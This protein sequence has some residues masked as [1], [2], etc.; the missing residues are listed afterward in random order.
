[1]IFENL[2]M[3]IMNLPFRLCGMF[4]ARGGAYLLEGAFLLDIMLWLW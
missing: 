3:A 4:V 1:M 2:M